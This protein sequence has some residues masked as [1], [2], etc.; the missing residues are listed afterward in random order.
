MPVLQGTSSR[1]IG[2]Q[3]CRARAAGAASATIAGHEQQEQ[4]VPVLQ[5]TSSRSIGPQYCRARAAGAASASIASP[6]TRQVKIEAAAAVTTKR[7]CAG[8]APIHAFPGCPPLPAIPCCMPKYIQVPPPSNMHSPPHIAQHE[9]EA[10]AHH[11]VVAKIEERLHEAAHVRPRKVVIEAVAV[12][13]LRETG[14]GR[15]W[16]CQGP[17]RV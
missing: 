2:P 17:G 11:Q 1:S 12:D 15:G 13:E 10:Q 8:R 5:G 16:G 4:R 14:W 7:Q 9:E 6:S 3:Y